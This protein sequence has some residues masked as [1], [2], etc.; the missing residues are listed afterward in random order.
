MRIEPSDRRSS[1]SGK[2]Q[3]HRAMQIGVIS[4]LSQEMIGAKN[5]NAKSDESQSWGCCQTNPKSPIASKRNN[6]CENCQKLFQL[7][8]KLCCFD[9]AFPVH[10]TRNILVNAQSLRTQGFLGYYFPTHLILCGPFQT[11]VKR[12]NLDC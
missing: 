8:K 9:T 6:T 5:L 7:A 10:V 12:R 2:E 4:G 1:A 11:I 3:M